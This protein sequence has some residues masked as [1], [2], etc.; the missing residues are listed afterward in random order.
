MTTPGIAIKTLIG[1]MN[2]P[3]L[4]HLLGENLLTTLKHLSNS[5]PS[6]EELQRV[7]K[8]FYRDISPDLVST[9]WP[10]LIDALPLQKAQ[11]L[12]RKLKF[13]EKGNIYKILKKIDLENG[14][15]KAAILEFFGVVS[16]PVAQPI[17]KPAIGQI[18]PSYTLFEH[19]RNVALR[20]LKVLKQPPHKLVV[21]MPTGAGKT[22]TAMHIVARHFLENGPT[23]VCWLAN[24]AELL[25][26]AA[27]DFEISWKTLGDRPVN[28]FRFWADRD[29]NLMT[30][31]DGILVAGFSKMHAA[32]NKNQNDLISI[33]DRAS[34]TIV[35]EAHQ[36]I[37]PTYRSVIEAL[38]TKRPNNALIGLTATPGRTWNDIDTDAEL[39]EFFGNEKVTLSIEGYD[40]PVSF[41]INEGYLA[42]TRFYTLKFD[43]QIDLT[44]FDENSFNEQGEINQKTLHKLSQNSQ[45]NYQI[46]MA[47]EDL[48]KRHK[49]VIV[50][51]SSI[52]HANIIAGILTAR[53]HDA[54]V[55]TGET[56]IARRERLIR[57]FK[58]KNERQMVMCNFGVLTT[59]FDA[60]NTSAAVIARPTKSLVLYSQMVG[61]ATR[62][63]KAG[64]NQNA[65]IVTVIDTSLPGFGSVQEAFKNWE[66]VWN[67]Y[68]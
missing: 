21:H 8:A 55:I 1:I 13:T 54:H 38:Y 5:S 32:Y 15:H 36:A 11:E 49:R 23:L 17:R 68:E 62:G 64:G 39:S 24:S 31:K 63:P 41:L 40:D 45:R 18:T 42:K 16:N 10:H 20:A 48:L 22:R 12:C 46:I 56:P 2:R 3:A 34:L 47:I 6:D 67:E 9:M 33:G 52:E 65:E 30:V 28:I 59:G 61:R 27:E 57:Q 50:F 43:G 19:Q 66:D 4:E 29:L 44:E 58:A 60:P 35:D 53:N 7:A 37:A 14:K 25:E 26:Q 51:G